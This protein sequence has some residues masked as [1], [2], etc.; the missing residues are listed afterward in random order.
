[1][2]LD[3]NSRLSVDSRVSD[4]NSM[5]VKYSEQLLAG[6]STSSDPL[7]TEFSKDM[8]MSE[9]TIIED[10]KPDIEDVK[11]PK[12]ENFSHYDLLGNDSQS[13]NTMSNKGWYQKYNR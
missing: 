4:S 11:I 2:E 1:M 9:E 3:E 13:Q 12:V 7:V 10:I 8:F 5:Q 6:P